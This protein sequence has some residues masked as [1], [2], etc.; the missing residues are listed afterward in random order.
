MFVDFSEEEE[1]SLQ[2]AIKKFDNLLFVDCG[3]THCMINMDKITFVHRDPNVKI[4]EAKVE[5][6]NDIKEAAV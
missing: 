5:T 2:K 4:Q 6:K 3:K 1:K